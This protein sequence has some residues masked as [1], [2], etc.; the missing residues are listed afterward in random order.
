MAHDLL[1]CNIVVSLVLSWL[2]AFNVRETGMFLDAESAEDPGKS[3]ERQTGIG[4]NHLPQCTCTA[5]GVL[6]Y[7]LA[8]RDLVARFC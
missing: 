4:E 2:L 7:V 6:S 1:Y 8:T 5:L 3:S